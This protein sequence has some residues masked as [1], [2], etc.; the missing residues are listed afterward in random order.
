MDVDVLCVGHAAYD[1]VMTVDHHPRDDEK[2]RAT[3]FI[4][5]GGGPASNAALTVARLG[6]SAAFA[7][8]LGMDRYGDL[9]LDEL[10]SDGVITDLVVR[11]EHPTPISAILVKPGGK[12]TIIT[13]KG[14][15][16]ILEPGQVDFSRIRPKAVLFDGH[17]P[18]ISLPLAKQCLTRGII[19]ILDA[20]SV[21]GGTEELAPLCGYLIASEKFARDFCNEKNPAEAVK[22][23][24]RIVPAAAI[25]LG[26]K[27][28]V[29]RRKGGGGR[30][31]SMPV[32]AVDTTGAGDIFHGA[33]ALRIVLG[34]DM[35]DALLYASAAA[36][37][38]CTRMGARPGIP[39]KSEVGSFIKLAVECD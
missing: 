14:A 27:G 17:E 23:L 32:D 16:P 35:P 33:F 36:A 13:Y 4:A 9:H 39:K 7:G 3:G 11:G 19:T 31:S 25:T 38:G 6:G 1:L 2:C 5:A 18:A 28:L 24:A 15:T 12:R 30:L 10:R 37:L 21:H 26:E 29:W 34:D 22:R 20:G 8:Y